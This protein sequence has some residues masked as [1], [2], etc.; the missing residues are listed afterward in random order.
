MMSGLVCDSMRCAFGCRGTGGNT[1]PTGMWCTSTTMAIGMCTTEMP[2]MPQPPM[3][4]AG[5][6][7]AP[8]GKLGGAGFGCQLGP[9]GSQPSA[10]A[11][12]LFACLA[13]GLRRRRRARAAS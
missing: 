5:P 8:S 4:D 12:L 11:G 2:T 3:P 13:V 1:C 9:R 6:S 10:A 7:L